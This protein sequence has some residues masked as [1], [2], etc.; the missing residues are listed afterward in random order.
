[1]RAFCEHPVYYSLIHM[2]PSQIYVTKQLPNRAIKLR[3]WKANVP[4]LGGRIVE[5]LAHYIYTLL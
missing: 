2:F 1:M 5:V 3:I 4:K